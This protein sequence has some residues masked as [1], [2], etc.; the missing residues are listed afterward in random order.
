M[1]IITNNLSEV[2]DWSSGSFTRPY[3]YDTLPTSAPYVGHTV[4]IINSLSPDGVTK[5]FWNGTRYRVSPNQIILAM[6]ND[7]GS[8]MVDITATALTPGVGVEVWSSTQLIPDWMVADGFNG[9]ALGLITVTDAASVANVSFGLRI[10]D[11]P[12]TGSIDLNNTLVGSSLIPPAS[13]SRGPSQAYS[14]FQIYGGI[15]YSAAGG[16]LNGGSN[17]RRSIGAI[18]GT[19]NRKVRMSITPGAITNR[20]MMYSFCI[21]SGV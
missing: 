10:S 9:E 13:F 6:S 18:G 7:N 8:P 4:Y 11:T 16:I 3:T 21:K 20:F 19:V 5:F 17:I 2:S 14:A 1:A 12:Y 15:F